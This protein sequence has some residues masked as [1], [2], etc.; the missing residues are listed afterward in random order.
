MTDEKTNKEDI[1]NVIAEYAATQDTYLHY[2]NFS[3]HVGAILVAGALVFWG[4]VI[5]KATQP[6]LL[7]AANILVCALMSVWLLYVGHNRQI[8][9]FKLHRIHELENRLN[10]QQ[11]RRFRNGTYVLTQPRGA[12]LN[13]A[14]YM[15]VSLGG[16]VLG[17]FKVGV[18]WYSTGIPIVLV[19]LVLT[20][21]YAMDTIAKSRVEGLEKKRD[22]DV[23]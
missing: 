1:D 9:R 16:P 7:A 19:I 3:W 22:I 12:H 8:Y 11:H 13:A 10:M 23:V 18:F 6:E 2:D 5:D 4:F 15:L 20:W 21:F 14:I 17:S